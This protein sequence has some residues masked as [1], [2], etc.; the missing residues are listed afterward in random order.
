MSI[1][2]R[3]QT[4]GVQPAQEPAERVELTG[5]RRS[6]E[7]DV[8]EALTAAGLAQ[9]VTRARREGWLPQGGVMVD[10]KGVYLQAVIRGGK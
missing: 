3:K 10:A 7:Y 9:R 1:I 2:A 6:P 8:I 4:P 5:V